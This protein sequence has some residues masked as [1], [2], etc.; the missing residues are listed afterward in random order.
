MQTKL[1]WRA[2]QKVCKK[3]I[4]TFIYEIFDLHITTIRNFD[5]N[6]KQGHSDK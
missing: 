6:C 1:K 3:I 4:D 2:I 5:L